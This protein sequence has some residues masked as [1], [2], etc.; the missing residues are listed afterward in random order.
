[1][2]NSG[3]KILLH[4][5]T[6]FAPFLVPFVL[7]LVI[8]D[9]EIKEAFD[10]SYTFPTSNDGVNYYFYIFNNFL[11]WYTYACNIWYND[12]CCSNYRNS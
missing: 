1:M 3:L 10:T 12:I 2:K 5:S 11:N 9:Q 8:D 7:F 4:A 6:W